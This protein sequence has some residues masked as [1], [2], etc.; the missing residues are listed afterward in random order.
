MPLLETKATVHFSAVY[1]DGVVLDMERGQYLALNRTAT[2]LWQALCR[3]TTLD[4]ALS[5]LRPRLDADPPT[6]TRA[7]EDFV[8][9]I[10]AL[11]LGLGSPGCDPAR[12]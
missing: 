2:L 7:I 5:D 6:L 10:E 12:R 3:A 4:E 1:G 11:G 8:R 9:Q